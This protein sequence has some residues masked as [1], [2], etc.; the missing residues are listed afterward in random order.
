MASAIIEAIKSGLGLM[1][2][3]ASELLNGFTT[4]FWDS[5]ANSGAGE[6]T[7]LSNFALIFMGIAITFGVVKLALNLIRNN[8]GL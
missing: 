5:T 4:L 2:S 8:T 7:T 3:I 1:Q 6:L